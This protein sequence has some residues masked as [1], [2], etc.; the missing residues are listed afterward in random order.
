MKKLFYLLIASFLMSV[1][2][3][4]QFFKK[5]KEKV[6]EKVEHAVTENV[7]NKAANEADKSLNNLWDTQL[8]NSSFS[9]G[10]ERVD[11]SEI[12]ASYNFD[13]EYEMN[14]KTSEGD[15]NMVYLL[16]EG[17]PYIG[18]R[19]PQAQNMLTVLDNEKEMTVM[20]MESEGSK[21]VMATRIHTETDQAEIENPYENMEMKKIESKTILGYEC[22]GYQTENEEHIFTFYVTNEA[23]IS[24][25]DLYQTSQ[26][27]IPKG[28]ANVEWLKD[29]SGIMMEM[30]MENKKNPK[31]SAS[32][33]CTSIKKNPFIIKT[34]DYQGIGG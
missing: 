13:W 27:D 29:D 1:S 18:V 32:M 19:V 10:A 16:K 14:M 34:S 12:P 21:M 2:A 31:Q 6:E 9:M 24:L 30:Q 8:K 25:R 5:L 3:E 23:G 11:P 4:A 22:Q 17:A 33:T 15:L 28:F 7:S 26:K 20:F